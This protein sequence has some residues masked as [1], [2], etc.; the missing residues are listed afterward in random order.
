MEAPDWCITHKNESFTFVLNDFVECGLL[1]LDDIITDVYTDIHENDYDSILTTIHTTFTDTVMLLNASIFEEFP[2]INTHPLLYLEAGE[3]V[4]TM[5]RNDPYMF[6]VYLRE[7][8]NVLVNV[9][10]A[11]IRFYNDTGNYCIYRYHEYIPGGIYNII[12]EIF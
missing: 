9:V 2:S 11:I 1:L 12:L 7:M 4:G 6:D 8:E 3:T 10:S 5:L